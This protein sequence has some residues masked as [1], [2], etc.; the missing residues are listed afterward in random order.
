MDMLLDELHSFFYLQPVSKH[1]AEYCLIAPACRSVG[2]PP[3]AVQSFN[4]ENRS[5]AL[6]VV[7]DNASGVALLH[8]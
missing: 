8:R 7:I 3:N 5:F 1:P 4:A 2:L 6:L